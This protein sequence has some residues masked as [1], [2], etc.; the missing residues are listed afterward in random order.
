[1]NN[2][3]QLPQVDLMDLLLHLEWEEVLEEVEEEDKFQD[4]RQ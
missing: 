2:K 4:L 3:L 1:V